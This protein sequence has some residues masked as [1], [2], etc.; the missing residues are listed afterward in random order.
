MPLSLPDST[1]TFYIGM[2]IW[3]EALMVSGQ[4]IPPGLGGVEVLLSSL[5][6]SFCSY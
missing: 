4:N 2:T 6:N 3:K 5:S 1:S